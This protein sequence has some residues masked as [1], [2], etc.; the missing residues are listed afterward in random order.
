V[1]QVLL[2]GKVAERVPCNAAGDQPVYTAAPGEVVV[3]TKRY[4]WWDRFKD[5]PK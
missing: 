4:S 5:F 2:S 1:N 3:F